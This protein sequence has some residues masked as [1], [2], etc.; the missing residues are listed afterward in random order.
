MRTMIVI[1][2]KETIIT[3]QKW[4]LR[5]SDTREHVVQRYS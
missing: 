1:K 3:Y 5:D 2:M 4:K